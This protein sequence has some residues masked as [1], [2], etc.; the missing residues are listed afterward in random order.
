[1]QILRKGFAYLIHFVAVKRVIE[2]KQT[3]K[4]VLPLRVFL[5]L[6]QDLKAAGQRHIIRRIYSRNLQASGQAHLLDQAFRGFVGQPH[7]GHTPA[8]PRLPL[9]MA[10]RVDH[11]NGLFQAKCARSPSS[12]YFPHAVPGNSLGCD[13]LFP[14]QH[15][16]AHLNGKKHRLADGRVLQVLR[17][18][19]QQSF[20]Q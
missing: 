11:Q 9:C 1:M 16:D 7:R 5:Y 13:A 2:I 8:P 6:Q 4:D 17:S 12:G 10:A 20:S 15:G 19:L 14:Q 3:K 18:G